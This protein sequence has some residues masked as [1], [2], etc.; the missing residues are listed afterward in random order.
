M[1]C[2]RSLLYAA[3]F[4]FA[5]TRLASR[6]LQQRPGAHCMFLTR[7][8]RRPTQS[9]KQSPSLEVGPLYLFDQ[10]HCWSVSTVQSL[11]RAGAVFISLEES[12]ARLILPVLSPFLVVVSTE[13]NVSRSYRIVLKLRHAE[14][15]QPHGGIQKPS[16]ALPRAPRLLN[17]LLLSN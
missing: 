14:F 12:L 13:I 3:N 4:I 9:S 17:G 5:R 8:Q 15:G 16:G 7:A 1:S 2:L 11:T 10:R 6:A